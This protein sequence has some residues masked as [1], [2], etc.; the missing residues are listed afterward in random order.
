[1]IAK[2]IK[3]LVLGLIVVQGDVQADFM[4]TTVRFELLTTAGWYS[5]SV[6]VRS[7]A[8]IHSPRDAS[9]TA[10]SDGTAR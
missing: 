5:N 1:M 7:V 9:T 3:V 6:H 10:I 4:Y 8:A 2:L